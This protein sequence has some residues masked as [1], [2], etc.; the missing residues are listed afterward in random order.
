MEQLFIVQVGASEEIFRLFIQSGVQAIGQ[1]SSRR[2]LILEFEPTSEHPLYLLLS[3]E[4]EG[5]IVLR[6]SLSSLGSGSR[7][8]ASPEEP[9]GSPND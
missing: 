7:Q 2:N 5:I 4:K 8:E 6:L 9:P 1:D 3:Q